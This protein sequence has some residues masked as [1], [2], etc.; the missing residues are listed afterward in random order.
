MIPSPSAG[1]YRLLIFD[2]DGT[3]LDSIAAI[4]DCTRE[5]LHQLGLPPVPDSSIREAI[6]LGIRETVERFVPGCED[7]LF[8]RIVAVYR[9]LWL[10]TYCH[11]PVLIPRARQVLEEL[12]GE[13]YFLAVATAKNRAG[14]TRD[15]EKTGLTEIFVATR[16][17]DEAPSKPH[18]RMVLD[19][20]QEL[21][22]RPE[23][24]LLVGDTAHDLLMAHEAG[25]RGLGVCSGS[26]GRE[27]LERLGPTACLESVAAL[28]AWLAGQSQAAG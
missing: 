14:L 8:E 21:G 11:R 13:G 28:P 4:V 24:A 6:G 15:L 18:P 19:I 3:L 9:E 5:T 26:H 12:A 25:V 2:W 22:V 10:V 1:R 27:E 16:T 20:L 17:V 7:E 23:E